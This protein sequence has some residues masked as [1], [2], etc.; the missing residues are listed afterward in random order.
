MLKKYHQRPPAV[1]LGIER[2]YINARGETPMRNRLPQDPNEFMRN[3][4]DIGF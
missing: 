2:R 4:I 1:I 3:A